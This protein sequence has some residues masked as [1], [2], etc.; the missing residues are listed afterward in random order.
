[1]ENGNSQETE[2][3]LEVVDLAESPALINGRPKAPRGRPPGSGSRNRTN[4][5]NAPESQELVGSSIGNHYYPPA[6]APAR[7]NG[8]P[9]R[10]SRADRST[11]VKVNSDKPIFTLSV[12]A[13]ILALHPRTLRIYE[14]H[15]LVVPHRT[16]T[17][18]RRYS[19][20]DI[21]KFQF[22]QFLTQQRRVNL[23][24]VKIILFM[25]DELNRLGIAD[26]IKHVFADYHEVE[27]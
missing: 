5:E 25:L 23:E 7:I 21:R 1:M 15:G 18:R 27:S 3:Q 24:G 26:P 12:A 6:P 2:Q 9:T 14:E 17:Q 22:I 20:N 10:A 8:R 16:Q 11:P 19:Q 4:P 13:E